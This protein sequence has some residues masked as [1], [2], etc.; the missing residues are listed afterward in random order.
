[1]VSFIS[2]SHLKP[3]MILARDIYGIDNKT[4]K[5][6]MLRSGEKLTYSIIAKMMRL[7]ITGVYIQDREGIDKEY[8]IVDTTTKKQM[9]DSIQQIYDLSEKTTEA[10]YSGCISH[11]NDVL[12][13][14]IDT[15]IS[16][17]N[18]YIDINSLRIYDDCTYN[19]SL[20]VT[21]LSIAIGK[22]IG[23][24]RKTLSQLA[25]CALLHDIGK[26]QVNIDIIT[27]PGRLTDEE[28]TE[29]K[30]H[31]KMGGKILKKNDLVSEVVLAGVMS[32]HEKYD[33][34]GYPNNLKGDKIP[35]FGRIVSC[36][37][38]YDALTSTRPYRTPAPPAE[39]IEY[40]MG[41]TG[42]QF[43]KSVVNAFLSCISP[44]P[45]G[46]CVTL[47]NGDKAVIVDQ[48]AD[49]PMRPKIFMMDSP[50]EVID[51]FN[52]ENYLD[53]VIDSLC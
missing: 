27:K 3:E 11:A 21:V 22:S 46:S 8:Q 38:V 48:N 10:L 49:N 40:I 2:V 14:L 20:G 36:A 18:M 34:T 13:K 45:I 53:V 39:A 47:S 50:S 24:T 6:V 42:R 52:D 26:M 9:L 4:S 25:L 35:L 5:I 12:D 41:G 43:D 51:L 29:I 44:Y 37:D 19:H 1:M 30:K 15:I 32:H 28:F 23:L 33:G 17:P 16:N 31:P 7:E